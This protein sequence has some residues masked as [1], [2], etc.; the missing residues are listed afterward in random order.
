MTASAGDLEVTTGS[1]H[2]VD[3]FSLLVRSIPIVTP[4]LYIAVHI[5]EAPGVGRGGGNPQRH[6]FG[7]PGLCL[8]L[9]VNVRQVIAGIILLMGMAVGNILAFLSVWALSGSGIDLSALAAG[10]EFA[11]MPR[12]I[13]PAI[14]VNDIIAANLVVLILGLLVSL[15]PAAKAARFTPVEALTRN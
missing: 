11:G 10:M 15:Y 3:L 13:Y 2:W 6:R 12:V 7:L 4:L 9:V 14:D 8:V 5:K 1:A